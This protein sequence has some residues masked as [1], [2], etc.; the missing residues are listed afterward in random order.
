MVGDTIMKRNARSN[1]AC[2]F[3]LSAAM[4]ACGGGGVSGSPGEVVET[5]PI[6]IGAS[7]GAI[8][9]ARCEIAPVNNPSNVISSGFTASDGGITLGVPASTGPVLVTCT[10]GQFYDEASDAFITL[11]TPVRS[12]APSNASRVAVTPLTDLAAIVVI[13]AADTDTIDDTDI[14]NVVSQIGSFFAVPDILSP[15]QIVNSADD[16]TTLSSNGAGVY[17]AV[18]AGLSDI[19][20]SMGGGNAQTALETLRNDIADR[21]LGGE[22]PRATIDQAT[23]TRADAGGNG[24]VTRAEQ[25]RPGRNAGTIAANP[26]GGSGG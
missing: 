11:T 16:L 15:P 20:A 1:L 23:N 22:I 18:L 17:A 12:I 24:G 2:I 25:N 7:L 10:G 6:T 19:G 13:S 9:G 8:V 21:N 14:N 3:V 26:T 4:S 5:K